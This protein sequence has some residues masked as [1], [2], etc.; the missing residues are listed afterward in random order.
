[1]WFCCWYTCSFVPYAFEGNW[2]A[3]TNNIVHVKTQT[4]CDISLHK[5]SPFLHFAPRVVLRMRLVHWLAHDT[6]SDTVAG[7]FPASW[8]TLPPRP[9]Q[10][11]TSIYPPLLNYPS[12]CPPSWSCSRLSRR[13]TEDRVPSKISGK[14]TRVV[15]V[16]ERKNI[17]ACIIML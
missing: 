2:N 17:C 10:Y 3:N 9:V 13:W 16:R 14:W 12:L 7:Q 1:M 15:Q 8:D 4:Y 11:R 5:E 6:I